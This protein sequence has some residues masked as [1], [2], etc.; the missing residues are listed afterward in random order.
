MVL[1]LVR[2]LFNRFGIPCSVHEAVCSSGAKELWKARAPNKCRFFVWLVLHGRCWTSDR[3]F[4]HGL[5]SYRDCTLCSQG[6][7]DLNHLLLTCSFSREV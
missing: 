3:L 5:Q 7:E 2:L 4:K 6:P 1:V